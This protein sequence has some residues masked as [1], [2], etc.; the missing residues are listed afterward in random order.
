[1]I[2]DT[3]G[4]FNDL[5]YPT[6]QNCKNMKEFILWND[7]L[8]RCVIGGYIQEKYPRYKDCGVSDNFKYY[9]YFYEW[10]NQQIGFGLDGWH[11]DKDILIKGNK[12]YSENNCVFVPSDINAVFTKSNSTRGL[13]P[14]GVSRIR[15]KFRA[16]C[17]VSGVYIRIGSYC[18]PEEA[19]YA[20]K[21]VKEL[22]I[23]TLA[24]KYK[25]VIDTRVYEAMYR[26]EVEITD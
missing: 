16:R 9:T 14:I 1:M 12:I 7:M 17:N 20:Y 3:K 8:R 21:E 25:A 2:A 24:D 13:Y 23:K 26:Y 5:K 10:C 6:K 19:F 18:T 11:L 15:N 4:G 22:Y